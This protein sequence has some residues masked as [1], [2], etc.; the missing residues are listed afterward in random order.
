[1]TKHITRRT[2]MASGLVGAGWL[3]LR[4]LATG[5]PA[6]FLLGADT[7][8][9]DELPACPD[10]AAAQA[11]IL[12]ISG[13]G[14]PINANAP[15]TYTDPSI[16]HPAAPAMAPAPLRLGTVDTVAAKPWS[17]LPAWVL[18]R[19]CFFHLAT[20]TTIHPDIPKVLQLMGA[21]AGQE[22]L[23]SVMSRQLAGCLAT[24]QAAPASLIGSTRPE[25]VTYGGNVLPNLNPIALRDMLVR[26]GGPLTQLTKLRDQS[27]DKLHARLKAAGSA[28]AAQR[29]FVDSL[30]KSRSEAR[31]ISD[32]LVNNLNAIEDNQTTGQI[33]G[34]AA[35][36]AMNV[37]PVVVIRIPFGGDNHADPNL[38]RE[39]A[40][41]QDGVTA[42]AALMTKLQELELQDRV[43]F[44]TLNVFGRTLKQLGAQGRNHWA[45]HQV[46]LMIGK[47]VRAGVV[48]GV[49]PG[50]SQDYTALP[51]D[52]Q[53]GL[54][55]TAGD[56]PVDQTLGAFGKTLGAALGVPQDILDQNILKGVVV[57]AALA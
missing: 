8:R 42:I 30:A 36:I 7:A 24:V 54:G 51:I 35:L 47:R 5:L 23:P 44:A 12:S 6:S 10:A 43:T 15:G 2:I 57:P 26:P 18:N 13:D 53:T 48:G 49:V 46:S 3:G 4:A 33:I 45:D 31:S 29:A 22:M 38:V 55:T 34:A 39:S 41:T 14:D 17:T 52:S 19:T 20:M 32:A 28:S 37:T 40:Q 16:V 11:L 56:I 21:T 27:M 9:G 1:M 25:Y 50:M